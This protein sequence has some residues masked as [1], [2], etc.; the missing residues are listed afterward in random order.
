MIALSTDKE[1]DLL[2]VPVN[3]EL[4][5]LAVL[6]VHDDSPTL[7]Y[8]DHPSLLHNVQLLQSNR[9]QCMIVVLQDL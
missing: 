4:F 2:A 8:Y 1:E 7:F 3:R 6:T 9:Q 5:L